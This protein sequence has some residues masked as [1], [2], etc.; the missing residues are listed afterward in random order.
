MHLGRSTLRPAGN[1]PEARKRE[2]ESLMPNH[3]I[4]IGIAFTD[5][6]G[7]GIPAGRLS[8]VPPASFTQVG[9]RVSSFTVR[10]KILM[11]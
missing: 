3:I 5:D 4:V 7:V 8:H 11:P 1:Q 6:A 9:F 2:N 10:A